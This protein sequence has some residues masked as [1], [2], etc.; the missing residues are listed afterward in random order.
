M[1]DAGV[2]DAGVPA[3]GALSADEQALARLRGARSE[4]PPQPPAPSAEPPEAEPPPAVLTTTTSPETGRPQP[5]RRLRGALRSAAG[6]VAL[7]AAV[8][9]GALTAFAEQ[10]PAGIPVSEQP[11]GSCFR[12]LD[13]YELVAIPS[14]SSLPVACTSPHETETMWKIELTGPLAAAEVRPNGQLLNQR[15]GGRCFGYER[16]RAYVGA[17]PSD[18]VG[19]VNAVS[20]FPTAAQWAAGVRDVVCQ[21]SAGLRGPTGPTTDF[22]LAGVMSKRESVRFRLCRLNRTEVTCDQPHTTEA[23]SPNVIL[24]EGPFPGA[25]AGTSQ[26]VAACRPVVEAYLQ[27][28]LDSRPEL[29]IRVDGPQERAWAEG[30]RSVNCSIA[31]A[32]GRTTTTTVR[33]GL[34]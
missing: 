16:T 30:N 6:L 11:I 4:P 17:G 33:G 23:T 29:A 18:V 1:P 34:S 21:A 5:A 31:Y 12:A 32:D 8:A 10:A 26:A 19:G 7:T 27:A 9:A 22:P 25:A 13:P 2:P 20:R 14:D 3:A 15:S 24:P 28:P